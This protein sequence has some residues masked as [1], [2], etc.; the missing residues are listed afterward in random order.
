MGEP[1]RSIMFHRAFRGECSIRTRWD[2]SRIKK[3]F[4]RD[5]LLEWARKRCDGTSDRIAQTLVLG[6]FSW[7][8]ERQNEVAEICHAQ[9]AREVLAW[10]IDELNFND[11]NWLSIVVARLQRWDQFYCF[12]FLVDRGVGPTDWTTLL[13][14]V[15]WVTPVLVAQ[16]MAKIM[17]DHGA[18]LNSMPPNGFYYGFVENW[19]HS[20][21]ETKA[22]CF[23]ILECGKHSPVV[24]RDVATVIA[25][26]MWKMR[27]E[28]PLKIKK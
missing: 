26:E 12:C 10:I 23:Y 15:N 20:R 16:N 18:G 3:E 22:A 21:L 13:G 19:Y 1:D 9:W 17:L 2:V 4:S 7:S 25:Q 8:W 24:S 27:W 6:L 28:W 14:Q 11:V 5:D